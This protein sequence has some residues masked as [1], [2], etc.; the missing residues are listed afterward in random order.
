MGRLIQ[1]NGPSEAL[2]ARWQASADKNHRSQNQ[3]GSG[4][5]A[6]SFEIKTAM[7][8]ARDQKWIDEAMAG[9]YRPGSVARL[10]QIAAEARSQTRG[11]GI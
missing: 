11:A 4:S 3:K 5:M 9:E 7:V 1:I 2:R 10:R 6:R 8:N